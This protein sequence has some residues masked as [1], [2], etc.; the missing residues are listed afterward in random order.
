M[1]TANKEYVD[2]VLAQSLDSA[3]KIYSKSPYHTNAGFVLRTIA[4]FL[5]IKSIYE[6]AAKLVQAKVGVI[7]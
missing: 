2:N 4:K 7:E 3:V 6:F 1:S 5:P